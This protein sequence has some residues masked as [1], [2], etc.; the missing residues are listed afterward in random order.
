MFDFFLAQFGV[1]RPITDRS[2]SFWGWEME[3]SRSLGEEI[4]PPK[5][6]HILY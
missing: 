3:E 2:G 4:A 1:R 5:L 6:V